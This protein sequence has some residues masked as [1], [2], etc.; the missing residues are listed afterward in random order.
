M[1]CRKEGKKNSSSR[2]ETDKNDGDDQ[3]SLLTNCEL[4]WADDDETGTETLFN[5]YSFEYG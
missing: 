3:C 5:R 4:M 1:L 2:H